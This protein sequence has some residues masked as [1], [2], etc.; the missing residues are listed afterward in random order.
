MTIC[1]ITKP[2]GEPKSI[3][4]EFVSVVVPLV[5]SCEI[6]QSPAAVEAE[7]PELLDTSVDVA[8]SFTAVDMR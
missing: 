3:S 7:A 2:D 8:L 1:S 6:D 5:L 4:A